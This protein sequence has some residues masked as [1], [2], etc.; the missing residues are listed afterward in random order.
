MDASPE[1][2]PMLLLTALLFLQIQFARQ[3]CRP[4][5]DAIADHLRRL[6]ARRADLPPVLAAALPRL[7]QQWLRMLHA[8]VAT[9]GTRL[10]RAASNVVPF[11]GGGAR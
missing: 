1:P 6:D 2:D 8:G 9:P 5:A 7:R 11:P 3:G 4:L 10:A